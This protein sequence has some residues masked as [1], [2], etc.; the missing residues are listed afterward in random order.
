L[1]RYYTPLKRDNNFKKRVST[2]NCLPARHSLREDVDN[3]TGTHR[4]V[5]LVMEFL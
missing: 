3:I 1:T 2:F 5:F 4:H